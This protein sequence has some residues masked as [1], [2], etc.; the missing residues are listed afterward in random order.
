M[1]K[2]FSK[3]TFL[4]LA[5]L[6]CACFRE[7][8]KKS[9]KSEKVLFRSEKNKSDFRIKP[10]LKN[11]KKFSNWILKDKIQAPNFFDARRVHLIIDKMMIY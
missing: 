6:L 8:Q 10:T 2:I 9:S 4:I 11:S 5:V 7:V 3:N 1:P